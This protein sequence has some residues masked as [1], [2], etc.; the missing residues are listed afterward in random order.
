MLF[1]IHLSAMLQGIADPAVVSDWLASPGTFEPGAF[2]SRQVPFGHGH[3]HAKSQVEILKDEYAW[4]W[5]V[6]SHKVLVNTTV[7]PYGR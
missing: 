2:F 3:R 4:Q 5:W 6:D 1:G 7:Q